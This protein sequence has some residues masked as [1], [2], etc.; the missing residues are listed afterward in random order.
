M[1]FLQINKYIFFFILATT[2][3]AASLVD[4]GVKSWLK[5]ND[6]WDNFVCNPPKYKSC[7]HYTQVCTF[8]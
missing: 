5:E 7:G 3:S 6:Y 1:Q 2:G 8:I 4:A